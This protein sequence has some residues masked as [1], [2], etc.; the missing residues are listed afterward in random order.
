M[1]IECVRKHPR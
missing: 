1:I